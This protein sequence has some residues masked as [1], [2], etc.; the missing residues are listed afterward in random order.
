MLHQRRA[1]HRGLEFR[2]VATV[3]VARCLRSLLGLNPEEPTPEEV[4]ARNG[5]PLPLN[6]AGVDVGPWIAW[7]LAG[8]PLFAGQ[9]P[10]LGEAKATAYRLLTAVAVVRTRGNLSDAA[11]L[12]GRSRKSI[13]EYLRAFGIYEWAEGLRSN[14]RP[15]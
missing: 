2:D 4:V 12:L 15:R 11:C 6:V 14:R 3:D 7:C 1:G 10:P 8:L 13:R 5:S 9:L